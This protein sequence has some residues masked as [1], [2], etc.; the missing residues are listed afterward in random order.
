MVT[1]QTRARAFIVSYVLSVASDA[2]DTLRHRRQPSIAGRSPE[3]YGRRRARARREGLRCGA[4]G[5]SR[6]Q[7]GSSIGCRLGSKSISYYF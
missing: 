5:A 3:A 6:R 1:P 4:A 7:G 2:E